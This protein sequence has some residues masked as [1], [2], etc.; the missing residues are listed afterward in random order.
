MK[1]VSRM[2]TRTFMEKST[3]F[4]LCNNAAIDQEEA[5][6]DQLF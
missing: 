5:K 1:Y 2:K 6:H 4:P 3:I